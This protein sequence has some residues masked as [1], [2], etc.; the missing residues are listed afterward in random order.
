MTGAFLGYVGGLPKGSMP[1]QSVGPFVKDTFSGPFE[2]VVRPFVVTPRLQRIIDSRPPE[3]TDAEAELRWGKASSFTTGTTQAA[4]EPTVTI[5]WPADDPPADP[6]TGETVIDATE[7]QRETETVRIT[8]PQ[9]SEQYVDVARA[10][11]SLLRLPGIEFAVPGPTGT[12]ITI[13]L[14]GPIW[15]NV[16]W[17]ND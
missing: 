3:Q 1:V 6:S 11:S 9:D 10:V 14:P 16:T 17:K 13:S 4:S 5:T 8:N 12:P 2:A 7:T 15:L